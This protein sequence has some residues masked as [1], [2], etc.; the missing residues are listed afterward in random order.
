MDLSGKL[1]ESLSERYEVE[2][3]VGRGGMAIVFLA[4]DHKFDRSVA[5]KVLRPELSA[6]LGAER[7]LR[8]IQIAA[9]LQ[10]PHILPLYDSGQADGLL[11]YVMPYV[12]GESLRDRIEREKQLP[13]DD[14]IQISRDVSEALG[15]AHSHG[16]VHRDIKPENILLSGDQAIVADFGIARA[17]S[18][19]GGTSLTESGLAMGTPPYMSPEQAAGSDDL[20]SRS[21]IYSLGC[22][23]Y[24]MLAGETPFTGPTPQAV[25]AKHIAETPP[26]LHIVR[27]SVP[28]A[29]E[30]AIE[31]SLEK[32]PADRFT[33]A[34]EFS[35]ALTRMSAAARVR[36]V[37]R[38]VWATVSSA[39]AVVVVA[40]GFLVVPEV[41]F[42]TD[43]RPA[44]HVLGALFEPPIPLEY[45]YVKRAA[46]EAVGH[47]PGITLEESTRIRN[48]L[49]KLGTAETLDDWLQIARAVNASRLVILLAT[50]LGDSVEVVA[51]LFDVSSGETLASESVLM[52]SGS[53]DI[54][55]QVV[56]L[57]AQLFDTT[58]EM[59][60][61]A[62]S[63][64]DEATAALTAGEMKLAVWDLPG[65]EEDC[66]RAADLDP[67][68][69]AAQLRCAQ[70][71]MW[72]GEPP[73]R[74]RT[75]AWRAVGN[76]E[77]LNGTDSVH[78][79]ALFDM[80]ESRFPQ[81]CERYQ[82]L[83]DREPTSFDAQWGLAECHARDQ[84]VL[85][86]DDS[87]SGW[88]FR[89]SY[90]K[91]LVAYEAALSL[92]SS[93]NFTFG[94]HAF[95][96]L[97]SLLFVEPNRFRPGTAEAPDTGRFAAF[98]GLDHD[99]LALVPWPIYD[100]LGSKP[101][102]EPTR[103]NEAIERNRRRLIRI[104]EAWRSDFPDSS[105]TNR[106]WARALELQAALDA[107][108]PER[109]ALASAQR[110]LEAA[111]NWDDSLSAAIVE[112]RV[113]VKLKRFDEAHDL[114][115]SVL[116]WRTE[117]PERRA[118]ELAG[119]AALVGRP[120]LTARLLELDA[121]LVQEDPV[122]PMSRLQVP[123]LQLHGR[124]DAYASVGAPRDSIVAIGARL[125][126]LLQIVAAPEAAREARCRALRE[127]LATA[128]PAV[129]MS[130]DDDLCRTRS[131]LVD[132]TRSASVGDTARVGEIWENL[133]RV[134]EGSRPGEV[135]LDGTYL[136]SWVV[137]SV[138]DT[139]SAVRHLDRSLSALEGLGT[140]L[141]SE[142][143]QA[144]GLV[145]AMA[146]R[147][148][149]AAVAGNDRTARL[150]AQPVVVLWQDVE[151]EELKQVVERARVI[152]GS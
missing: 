146:L 53:L 24:E 130:A 85:P 29:V 25:V 30:I 129:D 151:N 1:R 100:A 21:D 52:A 46:Y 139:A 64:S 110:A 76:I 120:H 132:M 28:P 69:T 82:A 115:T 10:H 66:C 145:R 81:A 92:A 73:E 36:R 95:L 108:R 131:F 67:D 90:R 99:T 70:V 5:I 116:R 31:K 61:L 104:V 71:R 136:E 54:E 22:V 88:S 13:L 91:A 84:V 77:R 62:Q 117:P 7:F 144:A 138:G 114:A 140:H 23:L 87:P 2:R 11:Y 124:L 59:I 113:L 112:V 86:D 126:S 9:K 57:V 89:S 43:L 135:S 27:P 63:D 149:L 60:T 12:E 134:R 32:V 118:R 35:Q 93:F 18:E 56:E 143:A 38:W 17:L 147:A 133:R 121:P 125:D 152:A 79:L 48:E 111:G 150:W 80:A 75:E 26:H 128:Y 96:R 50:P 122:D 37:K 8:E 98:A 15:Y 55:G 49:L 83:V 106:A 127:P 72:A 3:E 102:T 4:R 14:A 16:V 141:V 44:H 51:G 68:Y 101:G 20:D 58:P 65:A 78:A 45:E 123:V 137:L 142:P 19:A 107:R 109:S 6:S 47:V 40:L 39:A 148:E 74:W 119:L 33:S 42:G 34:H 94:Q 41:F 103:Q 97:E 105:T